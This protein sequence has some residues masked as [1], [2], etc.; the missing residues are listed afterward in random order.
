MMP[1]NPIYM[2]NGKL[3]QPQKESYPKRDVHLGKGV[4]E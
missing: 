2:V 3:Y 4:T 1:L